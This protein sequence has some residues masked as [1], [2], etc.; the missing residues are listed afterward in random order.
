MSPDAVHLLVL[1]GPFEKGRKNLYGHGTARKSISGAIVMTL[2][3]LGTHEVNLTFGDSV[4]Q[5]CEPAGGPFLDS[6]LFS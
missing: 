1:V 5:P 6:H 3:S 2:G 4:L